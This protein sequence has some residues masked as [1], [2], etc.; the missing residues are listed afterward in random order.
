M[1]VCFVLLYA[2]LSMLHSLLRR[3]LLIVVN[4]FLVAD[5][6]FWHPNFEGSVGSDATA[7]VT[8]EEKDAAGK[9][10]MLLFLAPCTLYLMEQRNRTWIRLL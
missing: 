2:Y 4:I 10:L 6:E 3:E 9:N 7:R 1:P 8:L 5:Y